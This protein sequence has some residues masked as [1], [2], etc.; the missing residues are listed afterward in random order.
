[1]IYA[2]WTVNQTFGRLGSLPADAL[3]KP[4]GLTAETAECVEQVLNEMSRDGIFNPSVGR[5]MA[6]LD[7]RGKV[8]P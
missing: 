8:E 7:L 5:V 3:Y 6:E 2:L 1:V 4:G